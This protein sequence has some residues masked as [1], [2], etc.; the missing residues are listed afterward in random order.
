M[1][2]V[3]P[4]AKM[5]CWIAISPPNDEKADVTA[6]SIYMGFW[7][8]QVDRGIF[9]NGFEGPLASF[10][11]VMFAFGGIETLAARPRPS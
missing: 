8:R 4:G 5:V 1:R 10:T 9:P 7:F 2:L 3:T 11:V 6:F